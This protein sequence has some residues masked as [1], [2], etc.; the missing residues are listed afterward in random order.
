MLNPYILNN[1]GD[2]N[3]FDCMFYDADYTGAGT[4]QKI[5]FCEAGQQNIFTHAFSHFSFDGNVDLNKITFFGESQH[6]V[7]TIPYNPLINGNYINTVAN[8]PGHN[9]LGVDGITITAEHENIT[10]YGGFGEKYTIPSGKSLPD[11]FS[12]LFK[13]DPWGRGT[14][15]M[16]AYPNGTLTFTI[17]APHA[18]RLGSVFAFMNSSSDQKPSK[19]EAINE[20]GDVIEGTV[21]NGGRR[22]YFVDG[23]GTSKVWKIKF[24]FNIDGAEGTTSYFG[25]SQIAGYLFSE[26]DGII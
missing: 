15:T 22:A 1:I 13:D 23:K 10:A 6:P 18:V 26:K 8:F 20:S 24:T 5:L 17:T 16:Y 3:V 25:F 14:G 11:D 12:P 9:S 19:I 2:N 21:L 7:R 4:H